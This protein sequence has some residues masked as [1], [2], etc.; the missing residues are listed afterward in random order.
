[1]NKNDK[2]FRS[3]VILS[4]IAHIVLFLLIIVSP[5]LP[6]SSR[7]GMIHYVNL[8]SLP[9]GGG[10]GGSGSSGGGESEEPV[11]T[12]RESLKDLTT[13]QKIQE[14]Q[15][16][17]LRHPVDK[18]KKESQPKEEKKAVIREPQKKIETQPGTEGSNTKSSGPGGK[19]LRIGFGSG[20]GLGSGY[21][22]QIGLSNF[23]FT[24][25]LQIII[26]QIS[27]NWFTSLVD[28]GISGKFQT[29]VQF[30]IHRNGQLS[31]V[32]IEEGSGIRSLDLSAVRAIQSTSFPP[33]P[34]E[35]E[36]DYLVI[37][38]IFEH[39]K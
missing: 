16:S 21:S 14:E 5:S 34:R 25:Y 38:L 17:S 15:V 18:P 4:V 10:T 11:V 7:K 30:K 6:K 1:M 32:K 9:G 39:S 24:Y 22:S 33:L 19:G 8:I 13:P 29:T 35:Y 2:S 28:P 26:D 20:S 36:D 31:G 27:T 23:P 12:K 37:H 3:A